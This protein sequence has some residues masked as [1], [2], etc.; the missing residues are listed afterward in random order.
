MIYLCRE[1]RFREET[2]LRMTLKEMHYWLNQTNGYITELNRRIK[3][4]TK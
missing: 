1:A 3:E 4:E 2:V